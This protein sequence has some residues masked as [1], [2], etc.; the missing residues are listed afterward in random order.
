M[1]SLFLLLTLMLPILS[2]TCFYLPPFL[3]FSPLHSKPPLN[4]SQ[5]PACLFSF[6]LS[7]Q[8]FLYKYFSQTVCEIRRFGLL[9]S[10]RCG[11]RHQPIKLECWHCHKTNKKTKQTKSHQSLKQ[12]ARKYCISIQEI[13]FLLNSK[14]ILALG[15]RKVKMFI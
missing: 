15:V 8:H 6:L 12:Q 5:M 10:N 11:S 2:L 4:S 1:S 7:L 14:I 9:A 3:S 13:R